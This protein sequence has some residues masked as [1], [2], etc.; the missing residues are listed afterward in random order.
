MTNAVGASTRVT[1]TI[2]PISSDSRL[3]R[4]GAANVLEERVDAGVQGIP[5]STELLRCA[6]HSVGGISSF[7]GRTIDA[8]D[9]ARD[10]FGAARGFLGVA[11]YFASRRG[12]LL[13]CA[14]DGG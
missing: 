3:H 14:R 13:D 4:S 5:R 2:I 1:A 10:L 6:Q 7:A 12:L 9:I 8:D 11:C